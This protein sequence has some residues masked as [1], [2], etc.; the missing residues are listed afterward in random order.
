MIGRSG[1][2]ADLISGGARILESACGPCIGMGQAP[3]S[4]S[5]SVRSFNRNFEGRSGTPNARVYLASP[6]TAAAC[7]AR[8]AITDPRDLGTPPK[9]EWPEECIIDDRMILPPSKK[10]DTVEVIRGPNIKPL[11]LAKPMPESLKG[12]LLL[13]VG[14]DITTDHIMP[15]GARIL[16]LRSNIPAIAEFVYARV[17]PKFVERAKQNG[18]GFIVGG[19]NYG[20]GSSREHAA[21]A[22]MYLGLK[23]VIAKSFAR[24]HWANLVNFGILPLT[25]ENPADHD[26][27]NQGDE[28]EIVGVRT[29]LSDGKPVKLRNITQDFDIPVQYTMTERQRNVMLAGGLLN[30]IRNQ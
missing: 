25:F 22:P 24:I 3:S 8:G 4:G 11:P 29:A 14:D 5:V 19:T 16:P 12:K 20:Q 2:L 18:G 28:F 7:A 10:P 13:K 27:L 9:V 23:A 26:R 6:E 15:A 30:L 1:G 17:D 21:L